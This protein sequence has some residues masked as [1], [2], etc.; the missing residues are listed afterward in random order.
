M[1][2]GSIVLACAGCGQKNRVYDGRGRQ[3]CGKCKRE[4]SVVEL[5]KASIGATFSRHGVKR[6]AWDNG[7]GFDIEGGQP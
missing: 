6:V 2:G 5:M 1:S 3:A 4:F 7:E